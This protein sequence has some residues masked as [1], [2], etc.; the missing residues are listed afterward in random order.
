MKKIF[1][2]FIAL[3]L[4]IHLM[5]QEGTAL[6]SGI[7]IDKKLHKKFEI[8]FN[9]QVRIADNISYART[10][11]AELG[12]GY[13]IN[14]NLEVAA[15]YRFIN[16]RKNEF[17]D[18]KI[19]H[20][21][22]ADVSYKK[23]LGL[24]KFNYRLRYQYQFKDNDNEYVFDASYLRNK[25][26]ISYPNKSKFSP[27]LSADIFYE[28]GNNFDQIRPKGGVNWEINKNNSIDASL[29]TNIDF[30]AQEKSFPII[31]LSYHLKL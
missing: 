10:F 18:F 23:K 4:S 21:Y 24:I 28:I 27:Y 26:E 14:K 11:L 7:Q 29:F 15:Y 5:A 8:N 13:K 25:I 17:K 30:Q 1:L 19:R 22:Y 6:W 9:T 3:L 12:G 20:R 31:G 2:V 16:Q